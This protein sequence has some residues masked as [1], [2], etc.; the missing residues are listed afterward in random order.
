MIAVVNIL[1]SANAFALLLPSP[2]KRGGFE[3]RRAFD[4]KFFLLFVRAW[5]P[6]LGSMLSTPFGYQVEEE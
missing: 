5:I 6:S 1:N 2:N 4:H 3:S